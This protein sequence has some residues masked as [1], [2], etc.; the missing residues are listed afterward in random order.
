MLIFAFFA[1]VKY[2]DSVKN[3]ASWLFEAKEE[4]VELPD[5]SNEPTVET[6]VTID[7]TTETIETVAPNQAAIPQDST[8]MDNLDN[9]PQPQAAPDRH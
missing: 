6:T 2:S 7:G 5:L 9:N 1:G 4:E 3:H 8:P